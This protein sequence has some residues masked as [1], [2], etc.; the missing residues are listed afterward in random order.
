MISNYDYAF[1][2]I[3]VGDAAVGKTSI[4][5]RFLKTSFDRNTDTTL[6]VEFGQRTMD[7]N[8]RQI[9][10]QVWDTAGQEEFRSMTRA[11]YRSSAAALVVY[12]CTRP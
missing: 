1:K 2:F 8:G 7:I 9:K 5:S 4:L 11:Y 12:D 6:G 10:M 3:L